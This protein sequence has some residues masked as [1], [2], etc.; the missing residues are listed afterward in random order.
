M[1]IKFSD[2]Q[3]KEVICVSNGQRLGFI[4]DV[5]IEIPC[6][7]ICAIVVPAPCRAMGLLGRRDDY[8]IPWSCIQR[9]G[10]DI[11]LVD[12]KPAECKVPRHR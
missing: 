5:Q 3:C 9:I 2:L 12:T 10:P 4:A 7:Q 6:G 8:I 1:S 11:V